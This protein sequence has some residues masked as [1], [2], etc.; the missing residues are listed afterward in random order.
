MLDDFKKTVRKKE[1]NK[2][3]GVSQLLFL[4]LYFYEFI[5]RECPNYDSNEARIKVFTTH[6]RIIIR[7]IILSFDSFHPTLLPL[8]ILGEA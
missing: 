3:H 2:N 6:S 4:D 1:K 7:S 5:R 8:L